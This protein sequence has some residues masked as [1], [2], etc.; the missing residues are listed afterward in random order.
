MSHEGEGENERNQ[1]RRLL[2]R[3]QAVLA[4]GET[5]WLCEVIDISLHGCLLRFKKP[6]GQQNLEAL[7]TLSIHSPEAADII[8]NVSIN[9]VVGNEIG[10]KCEHIDTHH[11]SSLR[12]L[13]GS[14]SVTDKL[15]ARELIEL[16]HPA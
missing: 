4:Q 13:V 8:M 14:N 10:F 1:Y 5:Q 15:L 11:S 6:W 7:Y 12:L 3:T 16:T 9:H 2:T